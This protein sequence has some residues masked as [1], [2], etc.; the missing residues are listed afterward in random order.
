MSGFKI[1]EGDF[2]II[3]QSGVYKQVPIAERQGLLYAQVGGGYVKL[4][5][6]GSTSKDKLRMVEL[7]YEEPVYRTRTG[8]LCRKS[9][10][11]AVAL[12]APE[13]QKLLGVE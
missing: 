2:A 7:S 4:N 8:T 1:I 3:S 10:D 12:K 6:D 5:Y 9:V 11:H 13:T